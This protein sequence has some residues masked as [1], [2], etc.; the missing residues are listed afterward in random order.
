MLPL[1]RVVRHD[2]QEGGDSEALDSIEKLSFIAKN[3]STLK[4]VEKNVLELKSLM[5]SPVYFFFKLFIIH[6]KGKCQV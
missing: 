6:E 1:T 5:S 4:F 2:S 3:Y